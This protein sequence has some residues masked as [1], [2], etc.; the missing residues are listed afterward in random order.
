MLC[1]SS[2]AEEY[3]MMFLNPC[4]LSR[5]LPLYCH[6]S[7]PPVTLLTKRDPQPYSHGRVCDGHADLSEL[8]SPRLPVRFYLSGSIQDSRFKITLFKKK[9]IYIFFNNIFHLDV[10]YVCML[11]QRFEPQGRRFTNFRYY[12]YLIREIKTWLNTLQSSQYAYHAS[13]F[14][15]RH[16]KP[17][18]CLLLFIRQYSRFKIQ[19]YFIISSEKLKRG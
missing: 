15:K 4:H 10:H 6:E 17:S 18:L 12:Y 13:S 1:C 2:F 9:Y 14:P 11:V 3:M 16:L 8:G 7:Y 19:D 5:T